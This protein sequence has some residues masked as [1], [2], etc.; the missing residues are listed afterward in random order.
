MEIE[1]VGGY[2]GVG[3][4]MTMVKVDGA[5]L[6]LDCG[7]KLDSYLLYYGNTDAEFEKI[8]T[9]DL[10]R[11]GAI[12][13]VPN[14]PIDAFLISHG[15]LDHIGALQRFIGSH[16]AQIFAT[17]YASGLIRNRLTRDYL[18]RVS[19]V[20]YG[21]DIRITQDLSAEFVEVTHSIPQASIIDIQSSE[22]D[23]VYACD[24]KFDDYSRI[25][26]TNYKRLKSIAK[27]GVKAL[28]VESLSVGTPGKSESEKIARAKISDTMGFASENGGLIVATTFSTHLERLQELVKTADKLGRKII[29]AGNS[30]VPNCKL[31]EQMKLLDLPDGTKVSGK[32]LDNVFSKIN[33]KNRS[34]YFVIA[35]GHQ[36][37]PGSVLSRMV[38]GK[39]NF[40]LERDDSVIFSS[41]VIPTDVNVANRNQMIDKLVNLG[42][43]V[44][45]NAHVSGHAFSEEH[46]KLIR[47][48]N[49]ENII[50]AH[51][52]IKMVGD[53]FELAEEEGYRANTDIHLMRDGDSILL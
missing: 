17:S 11:I 45:D 23:I 2:D 33:N 49:P 38:D 4:N 48:L 14:V 28:V 39:F 21:Q 34:E 40:S 25:A 43:R 22:G 53:Y 5:N 12:P 16:P 31:G 1:A 29:I 26:K 10:L 8:P 19:E 24:F 20:P 27:Q 44:Y 52:S 18:P 7:V 35:T 51:G 42:V 13:N 30:Y 46:R 36:G 50:P 37:E 47:M 32:K 6:A 15:H 3:R 9:E 41:R